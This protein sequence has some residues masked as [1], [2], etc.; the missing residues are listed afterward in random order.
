MFRFG[1][2]YSPASPPC[3]HNVGY[4]RATALALEILLHL[5][6]RWR[7]CHCRGQLIS[8]ERMSQPSLTNERK[9]ESNRRNIYL[10]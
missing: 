4:G 7:E 9:K 5:T 6:L 8:Y 3:L 1:E 2:R 10:F